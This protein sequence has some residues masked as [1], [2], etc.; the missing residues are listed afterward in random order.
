MDA[1]GTAALLPDQASRQRLIAAI[2]AGRLLRTEEAARAIAYL[3]SD[4]AAY[5]TGAC[6]T[7]DGGHSLSKGLAEF[8]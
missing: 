1:G 4:D 2:P 8:S 3:L 5:V 7:I 6:L